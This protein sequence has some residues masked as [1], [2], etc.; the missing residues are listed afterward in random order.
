MSDITARPSTR[1][2]SNSRFL[3]KGDVGEDGVVLTIARFSE[4]DVQTGD[5]DFESKTVMHFEGSTK[6]M[7]L[8]RT[9]AQ[10]LGV[11]TGVRTVGEAIGRQIVVF[12]DPTIAFG[13]RVVGGLRIRKAP[14]SPRTAAAA[15]RAPKASASARTRQAKQAGAQPAAPAA[16]FN[17]DL[18]ETF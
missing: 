14:G 2:M 9:N 7:I 17:D 13:G 8:N 10:L 5:D 15:A 11:A 4:E 1:C 3:S 16:D 6:P 12:A 18:P